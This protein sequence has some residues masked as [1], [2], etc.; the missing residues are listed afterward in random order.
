[1]L[2]K[3]R[4]VGLCLLVFSLLFVVFPGCNSGGGGGG[5]GPTAPPPPPPRRHHTPPMLNLNGSWE[6]IWAIQQGGGLD[7]PVT[8]SLDQ[9]RTART[10][11]GL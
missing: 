5:G 11:W 7:V 8:M 4:N 2:K 3:L 6:G 9:R 10:Y 1:M